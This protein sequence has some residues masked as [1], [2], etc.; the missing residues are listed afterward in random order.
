ML[1]HPIPPIILCMKPKAFPSR[2][3]IS[4]CC[5]PAIASSFLLVCFQSHLSNIFHDERHWPYQDWKQLLM[6]PL[7]LRMNRKDSA[8][9]GWA[10]LFISHLVWRQSL[11]C[12]RSECLFMC[13]GT[14]ELWAAKAGTT[15]RMFNPCLLRTRKDAAHTGF[16]TK[17]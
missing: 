2:H 11:C 13:R 5:V 4:L 8:F 1:A 3:F 9:G 10:T 14:K 6:C 16:L 17:E 7:I 12:N 15:L